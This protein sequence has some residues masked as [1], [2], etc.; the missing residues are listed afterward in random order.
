MD[1][2]LITSITCGAAFLLGFE[3]MFNPG[4]ANT[5][6]NKWLG[7]FVI[8][9][10]LAMLEMALA[11][12]DFQALHPIV[13]E[14]VSVLR[15]LTAPALYLAIVS[16]TSMS[17]AFKRKQLLHFIP[18][19][20]FLGF[21]IPFFISGKNPEFS[22]IFAKALLFILATWLPLQSIIYW[23]LSLRKLEKHTKNLKLFSS[24][25]E[26]N[27]LDWLKY[28]L[29]ITGVIAVLWLNILFFRIDIFIPYTPLAYLGCV[30]FLAYFSLQQ[31]EIFNFTA[32]DIGS[33]SE[34]TNEKV[35][36]SQRQRRLS[37]SKIEM[38]TEK[39]QLL[40]EDEIHLDSEIS[41]PALAEK[42]GATANETSYLINEVYN[43]NFYNFIN[44]HRVEEAKKIL[45]SGQFETLNIIGIAYQS[46]FNS[47][48]TFNATFKKHTG[49]TPSQY[50][51][52]NTSKTV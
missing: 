29:L 40:I 50:V 51:R 43:E 22:P 16:F 17:P 8:T 1:L 49:L 39:L 36:I 4:R 18:F 46:G 41:L 38:L 48:S 25:T 3:I 10:G 19:V 11:S 31:K 42:L 34:I 5:V 33:L 52:Q 32:A 12:Q 27:G 23:A 26:K 24:S 15:F 30:F 20:I 7:L 45:L 37:D 28:F 2:S 44:R 6:A 47:K 9:I 35:S 13:F 21:R 14:L